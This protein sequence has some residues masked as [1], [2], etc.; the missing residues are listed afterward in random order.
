MKKMNKIVK[1]VINWKMAKIKASIDE[2]NPIS[3]AIIFPQRFDGHHSYRIPALIALPGNIVCA[4]AEGRIDSLSD[5][6]HMNLVMK[7]SEDGGKTWSKLHILMKNDEGLQIHNPCPV[8]DKMTKD[9]FVLV[10]KSRI[11]PYILKSKDLGKTWSNPKKIENINPHGWAEFYGPSP[12]HAIQLESGRLLITGM[13]DEKR[14]DKTEFWGNYYFYSDDHGETW[15]LGH[16]FPPL[17]NE[18]LSAKLG[19][20][21]VY[22]IARAEKPESKVK[23]VAISEDGGESASPMVYNSDLPGPI[24][25]SSIIEYGENCLL[26]SGPVGLKRRNMTLRMSKDGGK[27]FP[28]T[29]LIYKM[30]SVYSD[31]TIFE[32]GTIGLLFE[33]GSKKYL[34]TIVFV[35][36]NRI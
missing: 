27:T 25:Q 18:S 19:N 2:L 29:K 30:N 23:L 21:R 28:I 32:D 1:Y 20:N 3:S 36:L 35:R 5:Y 6:A 8:Y 16:V 26:F 7:R 11:Q 22:T 33:C 12:G 34:E 17:A 15:V 24:C 13:Y 9:L 31:L 14:G 4:F 10:V